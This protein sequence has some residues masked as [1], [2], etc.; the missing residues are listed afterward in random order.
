MPEQY[1]FN[2]SQGIY[3]VTSTVVYWINL[4]T[5]KECKRIIIASLPYCQEQKRTGYSWL[6]L[7]GK[8]FA[9]DYQYNRQTIGCHFAGF[10][11]AYQSAIS[12]IASG[13]K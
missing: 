2:D 12:R 3:F 1:K 11:K 6:V 13:N 5:C 9:P 10:K 7:N 8:P 4:F